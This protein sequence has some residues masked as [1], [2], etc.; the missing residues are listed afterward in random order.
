MVA[1]QADDAALRLTDYL[2]T[3]VR[4]EMGR[5][6][7]RIVIDFATAEDLDRIVSLTVRGQSS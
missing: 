3:R 1:P 2:D 5:S 7:G 6:K 4:V